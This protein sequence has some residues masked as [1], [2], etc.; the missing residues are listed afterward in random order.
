MRSCEFL[1]PFSTVFYVER[2]SLTTVGGAGMP[3]AMVLCIK[4][5]FGRLVVGEVITIE[6][7]VNR[8]GVGLQ[9]FR[10]YVCNITSAPSHE[11]GL[12]Q[13]VGIAEHLY[14][15]FVSGSTE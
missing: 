15:Y 12:I 2:G 4:S 3:R 14:F 1:A 6:L 11:G 5:E 7:I 13:C 10:D 8:R 9:E